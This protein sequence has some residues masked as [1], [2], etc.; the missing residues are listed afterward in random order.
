M[1]VLKDVMKPREQL[2]EE[3]RR[4]ADEWR[5]ETKFMSR[6]DKIAMHPAYQRIIGMGEP[7]LPLILAEL[8]SRIG[9]WFWAL[10]CITGQDP[11]RADMAGQIVEMADAWLAWGKERGLCLGK[12]K[13]G[14][15]NKQSTGTKP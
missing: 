6:M 13:W 8:E 11:T 2:A 5:A 7:A 3:F 10:Q 9:D 1:S 12:R 14:H 4:L 15:A